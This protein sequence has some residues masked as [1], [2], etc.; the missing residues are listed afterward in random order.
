MKQPTSKQ[1]RKQRKWRANSPLHRR[2]KMLGAR[3][4]DDLKAKYKRRSV[5]VRKGDRVKIMLGEFKGSAGEITRVNTKSYKI[6]ISGITIKK[7]N[8]REVERAIDPSNILI[9]ELFTEDKERGEML[10]RNIKGG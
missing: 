1:P 7:S 4:S 5:P 6:Y 9:T 2:R 3:L 8:G 10:G